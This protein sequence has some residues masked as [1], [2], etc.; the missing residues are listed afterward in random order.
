MKNTPTICQNLMIKVNHGWSFDDIM[1]IWGGWPNFHGMTK[2]PK[3]HCHLHK[4]RIFQHESK[5]LIRTK[6]ANIRTALSSPWYCGLCIF[7]AMSQ[8]NILLVA[9]SSLDIPTIIHHWN[10]K[11]FSILWNLYMC[12]FRYSDNNSRGRVRDKSHSGPRSGKTRLRKWPHLE[13]SVTR[14]PLLLLSL[15]LT[16]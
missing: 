12:H 13:H 3:F 10:E 1:E 5:S 9:A 16:P 6:W 15:S 7:K 14:R 11:Y 2:E 8:T 4:I